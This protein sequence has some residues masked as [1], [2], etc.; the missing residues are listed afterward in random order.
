MQSTVDIF[1]EDF[2]AEDPFGDDVFPYTESFSALSLE[3]FTV[4]EN[5]SHTNEALSVAT[6]E[7]EGGSVYTSSTPNSYRTCQANL[8]ENSLENTD[9]EGQDR[10]P[11]DSDT[12]K[13]LAFSVIHA[14]DSG[15]NTTCRSTDYESTDHTTPNAQSAPSSVDD[16]DQ[17]P[18]GA[19]HRECMAAS[20]VIRTLTIKHQEEQIR[21][22]RQKL[23]EYADLCAR[24]NIGQDLLSNN[25]AVAVP[26]NV[27]GNDDNATARTNYEDKTYT[28]LLGPWDIP[29]HVEIQQQKGATADTNSNNNDDDYSG[30]TFAQHPSKTRDAVP[31]IRPCPTDDDDTL[32]V[33]RPFLN[34]SKWTP[35]TSRRSLSQTSSNGGINHP[36][37]PQSRHSSTRADLRPRWTSQAGHSPHFDRAALQLPSL[38]ETPPARVH[39]I[40][41][42]QHSNREKDKDQV[43]D[44]SRVRCMTVVIERKYGRQKALYSGTIHPE[45]GCPHGAGTLQFL[46]TG[47][48]YIGEIAYGEMHG[49][50]T[51]CYRKGN[52]MFRGDFVRN[53]FVGRGKGQKEDGS[54]LALPV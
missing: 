44:E 47:D 18:P 32:P 16:P 41:G 48:V 38:E 17:H 13:A 26:S 14:D 4:E 45:S 9:V 50:G 33:I 23:Q 53:T 30:V 39:C 20:C 7:K 46:K 29:F 24:H 42:E 37:T 11:G 40:E 31:R 43:Q 25:R 10:L 28:D 2:F 34:R 8:V 54:L 52:Q 22:L 6:T 49:K 19:V 27:N 35:K 1:S 15:T 36:A 51:Y 5:L 12:I 21:F 3:L